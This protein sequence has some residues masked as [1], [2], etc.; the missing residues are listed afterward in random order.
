M[1]YFFLEDRIEVKNGSEVVAYLLFEKISENRIVVTSTFVSPSLRGLGI[2]GIL[3]DQLYQYAKKNHYKIKPI[4]SYAKH[5][6]EGKEKQN[7]ML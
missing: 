5:W 6:L 4:C 1:E 7:S 2:A 3:M